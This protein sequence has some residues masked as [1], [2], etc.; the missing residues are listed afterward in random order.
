MQSGLMAFI[1]KKYSD[2]FYPVNYDLSPAFHLI[3][4]HLDL[5]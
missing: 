1:V 2:Y 3:F 4:L 5:V